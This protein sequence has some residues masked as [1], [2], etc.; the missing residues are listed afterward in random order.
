MTKI[1]IVDDE[2]QFRRV[3]RL[4]L[5]LKGYDIREAADGAD[6]LDVTQNEP[7]DLLLVDWRMPRMDGL[8]FCRAIRT[9]SNVPIIMV[10]SRQDGRP[11]ALAAGASDYLKKPFA[12]D[13][14]LA[15]I[16]SAL[17]ASNPSRKP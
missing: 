7:F 4:A 14:L 13:E 15:H 6:A 12:V 17:S 11:A 8:A 3:L 9:K 2:R 16:E 1:L 10:T 5:E